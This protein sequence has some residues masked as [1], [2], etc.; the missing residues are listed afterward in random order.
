MPVS[1]GGQSVS[2][3]SQ[4]PNDDSEPIQNSSESASEEDDVSTVQATSGITYDL[5]DL[6][7]D[8]GAKAVVGLTGEFDLVECV[9]VEGGYDF[10]LS[11]QPRV[12]V[13]LDRDTC[14]CSTFQRQPDAACQ[15]IFVSSPTPDIRTQP[16]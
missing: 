15:H 5:T 10:Q 12:H 7:S 8:S 14:S 2:S 11:E 1:Q 6:D 3:D 13:G 16:V 4:S 9:G